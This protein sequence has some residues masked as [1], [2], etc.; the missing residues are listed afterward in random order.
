MQEEISN[1][2]KKF[3]PGIGGQKETWQSRVS[4]HILI[5]ASRWD[6]VILVC[7]PRRE[8]LPLCGETV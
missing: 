5:K 2:P 7:H 1:F 6:A 4:S 3:P 8:R